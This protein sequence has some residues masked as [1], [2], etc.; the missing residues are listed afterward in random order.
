MYNVSFM[1]NNICNHEIIIMIMIIIII[2]FITHKYKESLG[3][4]IG[5]Q[6]TGVAILGSEYSSLNVD[7]KKSIWPQQE[8]V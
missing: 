5:R 8:Y 6:N 2:R 7:I 1:F 3:Q 4:E